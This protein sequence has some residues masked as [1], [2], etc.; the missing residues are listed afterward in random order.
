MPVHEVGLRADGSVYFTMRLIEGEDL[1]AVF[2]MVRR[3]DGG[4]TLARAVGVLLQVC[5]AMR[6]AHG[7]QI[8]HRDLKPANVMVGRFGEVYVVDWGL[9]RVLDFE[10]GDAAPRQP[11]SDAGG[12][13]R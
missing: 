10:G 12:A 1:R 6:Y 2:D 9:A 3:G 8:I 4:W 5:D 13:R 7:K 11:E